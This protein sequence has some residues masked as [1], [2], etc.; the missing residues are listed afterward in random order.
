LKNKNKKFLIS[1]TKNL[2]MLR[3]FKSLDLVIA[4]AGHGKSQRAGSSEMRKRVTTPMPRAHKLVDLTVEEPVLY[5]E[6]AQA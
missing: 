1:K 2:I 3:S 6:V 5:V 4:L